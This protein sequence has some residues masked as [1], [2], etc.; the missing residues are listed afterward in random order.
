MVIFPL[1]LTTSFCYLANAAEEHLTK[2][3][4][5]ASV[6]SVSQTRRYNESRRIVR[7]LI[8]Y[9][10]LE[11]LWIVRIKLYIRTKHPII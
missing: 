3:A 10:L 11:P 8:I 5:L 6:F 1:N 4:L 7:I 9:N 2:I